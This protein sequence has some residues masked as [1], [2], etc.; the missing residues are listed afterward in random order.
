MTRAAARACALAGVAAACR[1]MA[2]PARASE[3]VIVHEPRTDSRPVVEEPAAPPPAMPP[4]RALEIGADVG[5]PRATVAMPGQPPPDPAM[6]VFATAH[7]WCL[8]VS[9]GRVELELR[10]DG[11]METAAWS[12]QPGASDASRGAGVTCWAMTGTSLLIKSASHTWDE[13]PLEKID[14]AAQRLGF[15]GQWYVVCS[16]IVTEDGLD[17]P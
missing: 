1:G 5:C 8:E 17:H 16:P 7:R 13:W 6:L 12:G 11:I 9:G 10:G 4:V 3:P 14:A 2:P 15:A